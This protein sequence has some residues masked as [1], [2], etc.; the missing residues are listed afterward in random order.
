[1]FVSAPGFGTDTGRIYM[2]EWGVGEDGSTYSRWS[3]NLVIT[4][5][6]PGEG[7]RFG[8]RLEAN[9]N[10][11]ILAVSSVASG[12]AGKV[13]IFRRTSQSND[14]STNHSF[15]L[16]Q[17]LEGT[18]ADGSS[19]NTK[20]GDSLTMSKDGTILIIGAP[21]VDNTDQPDAGAIYYYKWNAD[22]STNTYT[23]QQTINAPDGQT[24]MKFGSSVDINDLGTR[25]VIGAEKMSNDR[26]MK[27]DSGKTTFDLQDTIIVDKNI[28]SGGAYTATMY[29]TQFVIDDRLIT[30]SVSPNDDFG[31]G[32]CICL[33]YTSDAADDIQ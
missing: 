10:G 15:T 5:A 32:V 9:D 20:F 30:T 24:N 11:D 26:E 3:Q 33:L 18:S 29:N 6:D 22:G 8:H 19:L 1:M 17:T 23:L 2:Y 7:K 16:V 4:S 21:G 31:R 14:D 28:G 12:Q 27:F 13:E 25:L